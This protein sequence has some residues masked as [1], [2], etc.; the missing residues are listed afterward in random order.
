MKKLIVILLVLLTICGCS[1]QADGNATISKDKE[2]VYFRYDGKDYTNND[3]FQ[4]LKAQQVNTYFDYLT[5]NKAIEVEGISLEDKKAEIE[6]QYQ[7]IIDAYG[8]E[9]AKAYFGDKETYIKQ[10]LIGTAYTVYQTNY[11]K[12]NIDT[13]ISQ[14]STVYVEYLSSSTKSKMNTFLKKVKKNNDF[15]KALE[16]TKFADSETV[17]KEVIEVASS[18]LPTEVIEQINTLETGKIS[19]LIEIE[20]DDETKTYYVVRVISTDPKADYQE[21]F[22][23]YLINKGVIENVTMIVKEKHDIQIYDDDFNNTYQ[24]ILKQY[25]PEETES[26]TT[27]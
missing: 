11:I 20:N 13:Y 27:E 12:E 21:E 3:A 4:K 18:T 17:K 19:N 10:A 16:S 9:I 5:A 7:S 22:A 6:E 24:N 1:S 15:E 23:T 14:Y 25:A 26:E 8:E 2:E